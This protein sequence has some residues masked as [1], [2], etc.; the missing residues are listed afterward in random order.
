MNESK[1]RL[2]PFKPLPRPTQPELAKLARHFERRASAAKKIEQ[3]IGQRRELPLGERWTDPA[4]V[5][6]DVDLAL[7]M[8]EAGQFTYEEY[9]FHCALPVEAYHS[10]ASLHGEDRRRFDVIHERIALIKRKHGLSAD[11]FWKKG[12]GPAE[13]TKQNEL[14]EKTYDQLFKKLLRQFGLNGHARLWFGDRSEFDR[15]REAGRLAIHEKWDTEH[16][17]VKLVALFESEAKKCARAKAYYAAC[18]MLGAATEALLLLKCHQEPAELEEAKKK[19]PTKNGFDKRGPHHWN[20][21]QLIEIAKLASWVSDVATENVV[22]HVAGLMGNL[23][24]TRNLVHPG[25]HA[26]RYTHLRVGAERFKDADAAYRTV[27]L[28][29]VPTLKYDNRSWLRARKPKR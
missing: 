28:L 12:A 18:A 22:V 8:Y 17:L 3:L 24:E 15:L 20:L 11:Q 7:A 13:Y 21:S 19:L 29:I 4:L 16:E 25:R 14:F 10:H 26:K 1:M 2:S 27:R 6:A 5:Q 23:H 9:F